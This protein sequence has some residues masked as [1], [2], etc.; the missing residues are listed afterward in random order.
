MIHAL[1]VQLGGDILAP[2]EAMLLHDCVAGSVIC[3]LAVVDCSS[4]VLWSDHRVRL[5]HGVSAVLSSTDDLAGL[6][7]LLDDVPRTTVSSC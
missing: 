5:V 6:E 2:T 3:A 1:I 7:S 4:F